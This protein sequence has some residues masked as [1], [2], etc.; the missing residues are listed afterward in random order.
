VTGSCTKRIVRI[1]AKRRLRLNATATSAGVICGTMDNQTIECYRQ[2]QNAA[3]DVSKQNSIQFNSGSETVRHLLVKACAGYV[4]HQ[5]GYRVNSE[6]EIEDKGVVDILLWG[7]ES[8]S[9][10]VVE[11]ETSPTEETIES[12]LDRY[13][14]AC[15]PIQEIYILNPNNAPMDRADMTKWVANEIG[16]TI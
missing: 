15:E 5:N 13:Y 8:R 2:L 14:R 11:I 7:H 4:A 1:A 16:L 9:T 10:T 6:V 3:V 12:K